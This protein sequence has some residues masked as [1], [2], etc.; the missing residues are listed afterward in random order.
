[1]ASGRRPAS[2]AERIGIRKTFDFGGVRRRHRASVVEPDVFVELLRQIGSGNNG[3]RTRFRI[4][5][6]KGLRSA[7]SIDGNDSATSARFRTSISSSGENGRSARRAPYPPSR[8][9]NPP[10][11]SRRRRPWWW[12]RSLIKTG[13]SARAGR[14]RV[15]DLGDGLLWH[16]FNCRKAPGQEKCDAWDT[17]GRLSRSPFTRA[18]SAS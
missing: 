4:R 18:A 11:R 8:S 9:S 16:G 1:M 12:S 17:A 14:S 10:P 7:P 15:R 5:S 3:S 13:A 6:I 2:H